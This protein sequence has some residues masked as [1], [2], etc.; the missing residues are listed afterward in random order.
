LT[1]LVKQGHTNPGLS[2]FV[3]KGRP[4]SKLT[5]GVAGKLKNCHST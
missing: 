2:D 3:G 1:R 4:R 5:A